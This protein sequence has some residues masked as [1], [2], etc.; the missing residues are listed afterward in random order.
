M[1]YEEFMNLAGY[2]VSYSDYV[3]IIEPMYMALDVD[4]SDF[5]KCLNR[6][7]FELEPLDKIHDRMKKLAN[8]IKEN[9]THYTD[10]EAYDQI[11]ALA[12]N[13]KNRLQAYNYQIETTEKLYNNCYH[14][15]C[16][17]PCRVIIYDKKYRTIRKLDLA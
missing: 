15:T 3:N 5:I 10:Y 2:E 17:Y 1:M 8:Q 14:S 11:E 9:C 6:K 16:Y 7:R 13:Y 12:E 4:K